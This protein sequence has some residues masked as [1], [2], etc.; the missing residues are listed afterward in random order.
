[1]ASD[2][3]RIFAALTTGDATIITARALGRAVI[4]ARAG[5][6]IAWSK[7]IAGQAGPLAANRTTVFATLGG[8]AAAGLALRGE[9][10]AVVAALDAAT[11]A[12]KWKLA[13]DAS[14]WSAISAIA[15]YDEGVVV[16]GTF[17]GTL[18][19]GAKTVSS[20]GK[21]DG[22]VAR[23][24]AN[25]EIVWLI[26]VGGVAAD[27]VQG[28]ATAGDRIAIAGT[29]AAG[30]D[31]LGEP[32]K[33]YDDK[34]PR[35]DGFVAELDA[36]GTRKWSQTFGGKLDDSVVGVAI[37][38]AGRVAVAASVREVFKIGAAEFI[39]LGDGDGCVAWWSKDGAPGGAVQLGGLELDSVRA[40][41]TVGNKIVVGGVFSGTIKI[42]SQKLT[43]GG[44]DD[45]YVAAFEA[46]TFVHV[47]PVTG[48]GREEVAALVG[49]PGGF[50]A[51][52]T[53]TARA[54]VDTVELAAP[55]DPLSGAALV[56]RPL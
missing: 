24:G 37:D 29:F 40:I 19:A 34:T 12:D 39:A 44:G 28:V 13:I 25:G 49:V 55:K 20:A 47:W 30:A 9:P 35:A 52:V 15:T 2:G 41:A 5:D 38:G 43:A 3:S 48:D 46:G 16:G 22:F 8:T 33:P 6:R 50:L 21:A 42:G 7:A 32:L 1:V 17:S 45:A 27:G 53:H 51:G 14:E 4:E 31:L 36:K 18:R 56:V 54:K 23:V 10:G 26:R 11:G